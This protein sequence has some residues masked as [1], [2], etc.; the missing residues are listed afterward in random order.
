[1][2][3]LDEQPNTA[4]VWVVDLARR[5]WS[6]ATT[7]RANDASPLW[8][9]DGSR[10]AFRSNRRGN[11]DI[12][13]KRSSGTAAEQVWFSIRANL[14][15]T[16]WSADDRHIVFTNVSSQG[17]FNIWTVDTSD[18]AKPTLAVQSSLN[19]LHGKLSPDG[20]SLAYASDESGQWQVYVQRFPDSEDRRQISAN[21]GS[22]P[23]WRRDGRELFFL[24]SDMKIMSAAIPRGDAFAAEAPAPTPLFQT[25]VPLTG[26]PYRVNYAVSGDG[27][28]FLVNVAVG[29]G[30]SAPLTVLQ[31]WPALLGR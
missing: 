17:G 31:N 13:H 3:K 18:Q 19:A 8:S 7:D 1:V 11:S 28:R 24:S 21:G 15:T 9:P 5:I 20:R 12:F 27:Q 26:N 30:L 22:E 2:S 23:R 16:D 6:R 25:R 4:D 14:I 29:E 10:I